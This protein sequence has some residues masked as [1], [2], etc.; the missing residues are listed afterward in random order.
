MN[1][2][3]QNVKKRPKP[4]FYCMVLNSCVLRAYFMP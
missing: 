1:E 2:R 3:G 4:L